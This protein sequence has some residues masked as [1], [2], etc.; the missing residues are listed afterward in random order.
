MRFL[1]DA[2]HPPALARTL[3]GLGHEATHVVDGNLEIGEDEPIWRQAQREDAVIVSKDEDFALRVMLGRPGPSVVW[4]RIG[5]CSNRALLDW[6]VP[7][8][9]DIVHRI[10]QGERLIELI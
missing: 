8:V 9:D 3:R 4:V 6:F 2:Q 7:Q 1:V 10:A 5:N